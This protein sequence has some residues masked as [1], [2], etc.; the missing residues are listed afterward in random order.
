LERKYLFHYTGI[1]FSIL[2]AGI[3]CLIVGGTFLVFGYPS[4][5]WLHYSFFIAVTVFTVFISFKADKKAANKKKATANHKS[6]E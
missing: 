6:L 1:G 5:K 2:L 3:L 4:L